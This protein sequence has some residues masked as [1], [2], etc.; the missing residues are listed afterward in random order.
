M[1][2][3][4]ETIASHLNGGP[5]GRT[6][7]IDEVRRAEGLAAFTAHSAQEYGEELAWLGEEYERIRKKMQP[8]DA[9]TELMTLLVGRA[10]TLGAQRD[11]GIMA[12]KLFSR[13]TDG[14]R[15]VGLAL[16]RKEPQRQHVELALSGIGE[17]RSAFEQYHALLLAD[18]LS[19]LLHPTASAQ[20]Q[21]AIKSQL[22]QTITRQDSS[23]W[24]VAQRLI[25]KL[26]GAP[27]LDAPQEPSASEYDLG[28][29]TQIMV[30]IV[31]SSTHVRYDDGAETHG[32]WVTTRGTHSLRLPR[33]IHIGRYLVTNSLYLRFVRSGGYESDEF[34]QIDKSA[35]RRFVTL[36]E[37]SPGPGHWPDSTTV[38]A[39]EEEHP[40]TSVSYFEA[41]AFVNWCNAVDGGDRNILWSLPPE[42]HWEFAARSEQGFIY[43]WGDA[44]DSAMCNSSESGLGGTSTVRR[45]ETG[46]SKA[47]CC[48]MAGN[49][50]E[51]VVAEDAGGWCILRGGSYKNDRFEVRSYL[52]LFGVLPT[53]RPPDFG[54]RLAQVEASPVRSS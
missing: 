7:T 42:D 34:W 28:G 52:R 30:S 37:R 15:V 50:W 44:F 6:E 35:R 10:Q 13:G 18:T 14:G 36:N 27:D 45:F 43:P 20:L 31:P 11:V 29:K 23:R 26:E 16:A 39:G 12:E 51:F 22:D 48:D 46:A 1:L 40:V 2:A 41:Q 21:S 5:L 33:T 8:G 4:M 9:R 17:S 24:A 54:F 49:V 47:G 3:R 32:L 19:P 38:P 25:K 53:H